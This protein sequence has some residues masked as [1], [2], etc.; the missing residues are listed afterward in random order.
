MI[1]IDP[2]GH[3][4]TPPII[5]AICGSL[6]DGSYT[7]QALAVA[8]QGAEEAGGLAKLIDLR[9]YRLPFCGGEGGS[10][11]DVARLR[12]EVGRAQGIILGTPEYHGSFSGVLKNALDLMGFDEV[13][14]KVVG[15]VGV[16]G[17]SLGS[18]SALNGLREIG[19]ALRAWVVPEQV[20]VSGASRAFDASGKPVDPALERRL[21]DLG[22]KV[23]RFAELHASEKARERAT[24]SGKA[25]VQV[26]GA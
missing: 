10:P 8:L 5:V 14:G 12:D 19:R 3:P 22:R 9:D 18:T 25:Q 2:A 23:A 26:I 1:S 7:R 15:L 20:A 13:E 21:K 4:E 6:R 17:G 24:A 16:S 11:E